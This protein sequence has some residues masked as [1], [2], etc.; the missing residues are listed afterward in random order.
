[1]IPYKEL[2]FS[3]LKYF[4]KTKIETELTFTPLINEHL[5]NNI[6]KYHSYLEYGSG[7]ST[8]FFSKYKET[9]IVSVES[10]SVFAKAVRNKLNAICENNTKVLTANIG[11]TGFWGY[12][13]FNRNSAKKGWK[14]VNTPWQHLGNEYK[15]DIVLI[16]GRYRIACAL[17]I[18]YRASN[19]YAVTIII[20][21]YV[22]REEYS[23]FEK[24]CP[25]S[26]TIERM[27]L[28]EY[29]KFHINEE[30]LRNIEIALNDYLKK[31]E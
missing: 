20:D 10:D 22:G 8:V 30:Q 5:I 18:L 1:M 23:F 27:A 24:F 12:P 31:V 3:I 11:L 14:Y 26:K 7:A 29:N 2:K 17:N 15:P 9:N 6:K 16:D 21:D 28:F 4:K 13:M 25:I 19:K